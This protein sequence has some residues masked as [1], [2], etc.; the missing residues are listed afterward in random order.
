MRPKLRKEDIDL[1]FDNW[2]NS[3]FE[4]IEV[5]ELKPGSV[6]ATIKPRNHVDPDKRRRED[7]LARRISERVKSNMFEEFA[8][9]IWDTALPNGVILRDARGKDLKHA[10]GWYAELAKRLAP[11][12]RLYKKFSTKQL[13]DLSRREA[14]A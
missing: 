3:N 11:T 10:T 9:R 2:L 13:F 12:E 7:V 8:A 4:R 6:V 5:R 14:F 1:L